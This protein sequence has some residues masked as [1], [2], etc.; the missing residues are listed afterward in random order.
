TEQSESYREPKKRPAHTAEPR[1]R[2]DG[3]LGRDG[4]L[5]EGVL[6][7]RADANEV[8]LRGRPGGLRAARRLL[9]RR[10]DAARRWARRGGDPATDGVPGG[11]ARPVHRGHP[12]R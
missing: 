10:A 2:A 11:N 9:T 7:P 5:A 8:L 6:R 12:R 3:D 1:G 4:R